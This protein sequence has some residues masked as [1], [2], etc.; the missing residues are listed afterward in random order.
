MFVGVAIGYAAALVLLIVEIRRFL[1]TVI[2][3]STASIDAT[4]GTINAPDGFC[5][6]A[7]STAGGAS[8]I[9]LLNPA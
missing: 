1:G 5:T 7:T 9:M 8:A 3:V 6:A 2:P 4:D